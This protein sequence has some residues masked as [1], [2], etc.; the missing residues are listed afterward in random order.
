MCHARC[1]AAP[2][3]FCWPYLHGHGATAQLGM[4][5]LVVDAARVVAVESIKELSTLVLGCMQAQSA[6]L[7]A[8]RHA[9][10]DGRAGWETVER[11]MGRGGWGDSAGTGVATMRRR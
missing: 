3:L 4:Q 6:N 1:R 5:L 9:D 8:A 7:H 2:L 11:R 10:Q